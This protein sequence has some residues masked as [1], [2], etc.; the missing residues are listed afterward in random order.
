[1]F[2]YN[3]IAL[4]RYAA[5]IECIDIRDREIQWNWIVARESELPKSRLLV[6]EK[7]S[8]KRSQ[9]TQQLPKEELSSNIRTRPQTRDLVSQLQL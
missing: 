5:C 4:F 8:I 6:I 1:M 9:Q 3:S 2:D 7:E